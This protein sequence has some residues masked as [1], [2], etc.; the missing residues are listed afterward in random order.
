M[1]Q[2]VRPMRKPSGFSVFKW[3]AASP[4]TSALRLVAGIAT[5]AGVPGAA[6]ATLPSQYVD[7]R[8]AAQLREAHGALL[9]RVAVR[10]VL[11]ARGT[12]VPG[13][14]RSVAPEPRQTS[15]GMAAKLARYS[16]TNPSLAMAA[17]GSVPLL[18]DVFGLA[19]LPMHVKEIEAAERRQALLARSVM[20]MAAKG[21][22]IP[23]AVPRLG[24]S[25]ST[26]TRFPVAGE[27]QRTVDAARARA[28]IMRDLVRSPSFY[29]KQAKVAWLERGRAVGRAAGVVS[30]YRPYRQREGRDYMLAGISGRGQRADFQLGARKV[31]RPRPRQ[32]RA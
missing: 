3:F 15:E 18:G 22:A 31:K 29:L 16:Q 6:L 27:P 1:A 21:S 32:G 14:F 8:K 7:A 25:L 11:A 12:P 10:G 17:I 20:V 24:E 23:S 28:E 30:G 2:I 5:L 13:A 9:R 19:A 4:I 26:T